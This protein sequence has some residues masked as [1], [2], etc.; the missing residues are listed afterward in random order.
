MT[1][2]IIALIAISVLATSLVLS[3]PLELENEKSPIYSYIEKSDY[4][5]QVAW[6]MADQAITESFADHALEKCTQA[7]HLDELN[8]KT[9]QY[10]QT[11]NLQRENLPGCR[12][13]R[14][15]SNFTGSPGTEQYNVA[16]EISCTAGGIADGLFVELKKNYDFNMLR[17]NSDPC[18]VTITDLDSGNAFTQS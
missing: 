1:N 14:L 8:Q 4:K 7:A 3:R 17:S 11:I 15:G 10:L 13:A 16:V 2:S 6:Y 5:K 9:D 12:V 18:T